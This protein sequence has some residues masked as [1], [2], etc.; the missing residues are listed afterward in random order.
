MTVIEILTSTEKKSDGR[1]TSE[2][3]LYIASIDSSAEHLSLITRR[4]WAIENMHRDLDRNL[5][6]DNIKRKTERADRNLDTIQ[7]VALAL[8]A[9]WKNKRKKMAEKD[10]GTA[11]IARELSFSFTKILHFL[12]QK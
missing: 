1:S 10:K 8:F 5:R 2:Q 7:K 9:I 6:Q 3:R 12:E 4:H 11:E